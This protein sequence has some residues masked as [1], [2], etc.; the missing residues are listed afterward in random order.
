MGD[1]RAPRPFD[2][3]QVKP[4]PPPAPPPKRFARRF[5]LRALAAVAFLGK[6]APQS[7][8]LRVPDVSTIDVSAIETA[9]E[10]LRS[11]YVQ[12]PRRRR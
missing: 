9:A 1:R 10:E 5:F 8:Q 6:A 11:L 7:V 2:P 12:D 3:S 4:V